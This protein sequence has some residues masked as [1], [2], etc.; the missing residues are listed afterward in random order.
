MTQVVIQ[1]TNAVLWRAAQARMAEITA[2]IEWIAVRVVEIDGLLAGMAPGDPERLPLEAEQAALLLEH[3][4]LL[5]E[6][7]ALDGSW[8]EDV[9]V[10]MDPLPMSEADAIAADAAA[11]AALAQRKITYAANRT[12]LEDW[13]NSP[14]TSL[15][16]LRAA[17]GIL[18]LIVREKIYD[19]DLE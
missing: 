8:L 10:E 15:P 5:A 19:A 7:A 18:A 4:D 3:Q 16:A 17:F 12:L 14:P 1:S 2:R 6:E 13:N 9:T 11:A